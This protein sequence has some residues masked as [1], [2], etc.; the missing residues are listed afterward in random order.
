MHILPQKHGIP[1]KSFIP[2]LNIYSLTRKGKV[3][4]SQ[5]RG[6]AYF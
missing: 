3:G 4:E 1:K 2:R 5:A 6:I